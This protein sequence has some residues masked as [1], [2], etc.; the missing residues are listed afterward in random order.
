MCIALF[1]FDIVF[2]AHKFAFYFIIK[3]RG[4][5]NAYNDLK[6]FYFLFNRPINYA[7]NY[8]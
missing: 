1:G 6:L 5:C 3:C 7:G 2:V 4:I 8:Y